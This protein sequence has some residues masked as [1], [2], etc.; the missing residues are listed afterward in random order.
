MKI[1]Y[2]KILN[3]YDRYEAA[4]KYLE[5]HYG[6]HVPYMHHELVSHLVRCLEGGVSEQQFQRD[7]RH[8]YNI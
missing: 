3:Q 7:A 2:N 8:M 6:A 1:R 5:D 4:Y